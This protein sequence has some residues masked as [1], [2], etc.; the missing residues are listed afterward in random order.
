MAM[1]H[2]IFY[3][4]PKYILD[5][6]KRVGLDVFLEQWTVLIIWKKVFNQFYFFKRDS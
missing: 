1:L 2:T 4:T 5:I 6:L 3:Y